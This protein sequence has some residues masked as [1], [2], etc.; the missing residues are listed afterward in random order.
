M[1]GWL[2]VHPATSRRWWTWVCV[3]KKGSKKDDWSK[4]VFPLEVQKR[5]SM[6]L[7][8]WKGSLND[9]I[10]LINILPPL[11]PSRKLFKIRVI[12]PNFNHINNN[13][14]LDNWL[15]EHNL[16][17]F[18]WS[19]QSFSQC[20]CKRIWSTPRHL[21]RCRKD[22]QQGIGLTNLVFFIKGHQITMWSAVLFEE[23]SSK[24]NPS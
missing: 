12:S 9:E 21:P 10:Q 24:V 13:N 8:W 7:V 3:W 6:R 20:C 15:Q 4:I 1:R 16:T 2:Q 11:Y 17:W 5:K 19:M 18:P 23:Y 14:N 22:C